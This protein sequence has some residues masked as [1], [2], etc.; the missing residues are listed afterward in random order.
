MAAPMPLA[1]PVRRMVFDFD[2]FGMNNPL[3]CPLLD[4]GPRRGD[5]RCAID[6]RVMSHSGEL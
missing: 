2:F 1:P 4:R 3:R 6:L 5:E